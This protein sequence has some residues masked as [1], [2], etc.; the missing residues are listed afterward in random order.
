V[1][2]IACSG[3]RLTFAAGALNYR[4]EAVAIGNDP[5]AEWK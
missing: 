5:P 2:S 1:P 4:V 3:R